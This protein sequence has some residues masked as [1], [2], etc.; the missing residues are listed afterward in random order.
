[1]SGDRV[2]TLASTITG[3]GWVAGGQGAGSMTALDATVK[4]VDALSSA[5]F[6]F[7]TGYVQPLQDVC[8]RMAGKASVVS[9]FADTWQ[10]VSTRA[11]QVRERLTRSATT[12][13]AQ[14]SGAAGDRYRTH[15]AGIASALEQVVAL[16]KAGSSATTAA[17]NAVAGGRQQAADLLTDLVQRLIS[18]V[19]RAIAIEGGITSNV[20]AESTRM[21]NSYGV[22]IS[23][24]E[25]QVRQSIT[26][27]TPLLTELANAI[28]GAPT[29]T[30]S[31]TD[32]TTAV[33]STTTRAAALVR[34]ESLTAS[35][36]Q[37]P[38][39]TRGLVFAQAQTTGGGRRS[40]GTVLNIPGGKVLRP[41]P[42]GVYTVPSQT[43]V[44]E[45]GVRRLPQSGQN[46]MRLQDGTII[47]FVPED[48]VP[49]S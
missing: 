13:T 48:K 20:L 3:G 14:W 15:S 16:A 4:P 7:L 46:T 37:E 8:D 21:I 19:S 26:N 2:A 29:T 18:Y 27:V 42:G 40:G 41:K 47:R 24:V 17:G 25:Q 44:W 43:E 33:S 31:T 1:M 10:Q 9:S 34:P 32:G 5:G 35:A 30:S 45:N 36:P 49:T 23:A 39:T 12:D 11:D 6:G 38:A 22:P 28:Q